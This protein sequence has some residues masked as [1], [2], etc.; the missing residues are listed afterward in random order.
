MAKAQFSDSPVKSKAVAYVYLLKDLADDLTSGN[1]RD[2]R[3]L[4]GFPG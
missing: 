4:C 1:L 2:L 3:F